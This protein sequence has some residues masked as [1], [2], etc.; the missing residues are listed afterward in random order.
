MKDYPLGRIGGFRVSADSSAL[1]GAPLLWAVLAAG[2]RAMGVPWGRAV[3][4][5]LVTS[6]VH[7][8]SELWHQGGHAL[9]ARSAGY[10]MTGLRFWTILSA[11]VYPADEPALPARIHIRRA[12]GGPLAS[13][14]LTV[15]MGL[16]W[17]ATP[18]TQHRRHALARFAFWEN[19]IVFTLGALVP[20]GFNDGSSLRHWW[21]KR[22]A[23][24]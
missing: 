18:R 16:L 2:V 1:V 19:L 13:A 20:L 5:G 7:W 14:L 3:R 6:G 15:A 24:C 22:S 17:R 11:S 4:V 21:P 23:E 10:P 12:L 9:A 8:A